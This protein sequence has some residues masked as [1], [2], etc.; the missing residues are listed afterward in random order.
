M[1]PMGQEIM[2]AAMGIIAPAVGWLFFQVITQKE[3]VASIKESIEKID[4]KQD[5]I[6]EHILD[7]KGR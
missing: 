7:S 5:L 6:L 3:T 4:R 1:S 2:A